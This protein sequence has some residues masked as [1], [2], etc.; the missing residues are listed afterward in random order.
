[1]ITILQAK[2]LPYLDRDTSVLDGGM[3]ELGGEVAGV[4]AHPQPVMPGRCGA[5]LLGDPA[6]RATQQRR[7]PGPDVVAGQ[8]LR[9]LVVRPASAQVARC[10]RPQRCPA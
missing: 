10:G 6:Q 8:Q 4:R 2:R 1:M 3:G 7:G 5:C 9:C